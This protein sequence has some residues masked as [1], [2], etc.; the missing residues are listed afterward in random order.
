MAELLLGVAVW[1]VLAT[2]VVSGIFLMVVIWGG[3]AAIVWE[4]LH[5]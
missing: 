3:L 1:S 2:A 5:G 4:W